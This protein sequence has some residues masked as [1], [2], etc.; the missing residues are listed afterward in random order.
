MPH[1]ALRSVLSPVPVGNRDARDE[2]SKIQHCQQPADAA[3]RV[4]AGASGQKQPGIIERV[5]PHGASPISCEEQRLSHSLLVSAMIYVVDAKFFESTAEDA[6][7]C[8]ES[9]PGVV[10]DRARVKSPVPVMRRLPRRKV[11]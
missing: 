6:D 2:E 10:R 7:R 3:R 1:R 11:K 5:G 8:L 4:L 9:A